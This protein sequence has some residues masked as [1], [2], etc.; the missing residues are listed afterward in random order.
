MAGRLEGMWHESKGW[1][2][3]AERVYD[4]LLETNPA[5]QV[6]PPHRAQLEVVGDTTIF[7]RYCHS[8]PEEYVVKKRV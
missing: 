3:Q 5:N 6:R 4:D 8:R 1:W 7:P 2:D